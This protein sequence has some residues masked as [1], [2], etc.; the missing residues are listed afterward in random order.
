MATAGHLLAGVLLLLADL[1]GF[2]M[3]LQQP[4]YQLPWCSLELSI[5]IQANLPASC[6][7]HIIDRA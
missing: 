6:A 3:L 1:C 5:Y 2:S 4:H 7:Q